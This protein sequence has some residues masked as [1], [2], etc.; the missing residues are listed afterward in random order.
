V[1]LPEEADMQ[2]HEYSHRVRA[3]MAS[4]SFHPKRKKAKP[5]LFRYQDLHLC[6]T[7]PSFLHSAEL[8]LV[9]GVHAPEELYVAP[10]RKRA[11]RPRDPTDEAPELLLLDDED[12]GEDGAEGGAKPGAGGDAA[13]KGLLPGEEEGE[14]EPEEDEDEGDY[15][16][17]YFDGGDDYEERESGEDEAFY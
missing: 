16:E 1:G 12:E 10:P 17:N 7:Q 4:S 8:R 15:G 6:T 13:K 9:K 3:F 5:D 14:E 2:R 11:K